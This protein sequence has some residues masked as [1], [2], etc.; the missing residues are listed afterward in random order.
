MDTPLDPI[1]AHQRRA[2]AFMLDT[3]GLQDARD[4]ALRAARGLELEQR[5]GALLAENRRLRM[6]IGQLE[7]E[8]Y[9][10]ESK[11]EVREGEISSRLAGERSRRLDDI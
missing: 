7:H 8:L 10:E 6:R 9:P 5:V 3:L 2:L 4:E 1:H 11:L